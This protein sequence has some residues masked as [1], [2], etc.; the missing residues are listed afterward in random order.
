MDAGHISAP[1]LKQ[2]KSSLKHCTF[3]QDGK[4]VATVG[5][6]AGMAKVQFFDNCVNIFDLHACCDGFSHQVTRVLQAQVHET[7][8][9]IITGLKFLNEHILASASLDGTVKLQSVYGESHMR[10]HTLGCGAPVECLEHSPARDLLA[11]GA[12][13]GSVTL[14]SLQWEH[15]DIGGE[16][17]PYLSEAPAVAHRFWNVVRGNP[18]SVLAFNPDGSLLATG[19]H[20][21]R[22]ETQTQ[23]NGQCVTLWNTADGECH[24]SFQCH[25]WAFKF[26]PAVI[27]SP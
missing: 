26:L 23:R 15:K 11:A 10:R 6:A 2:L 17:V 1:G 20:T 16:N 24:A 12:K 4:F 19:T 5:G 3:S 7:H 8:E 22:G 21:Q 14:W 18:I 27:P 25:V 9:M 13:N